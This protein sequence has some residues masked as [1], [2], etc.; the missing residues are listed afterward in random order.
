MDLTHISPVAALVQVDRIAKIR[1]IT[2]ENL[3]KLIGTQTEKPLLG[4]FGTTKINVLKLN[5]ALN[6]LK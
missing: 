1:D 6:N 4:L 3:V 5:L 2:K